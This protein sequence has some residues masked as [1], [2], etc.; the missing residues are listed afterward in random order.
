MRRVESGVMEGKKI[1]LMKSEDFEVRIIKFYKFLT[2]TKKEFVL[3]K[4]VLRSGTGIGA[5]LSE[6]EC[7]ISKSDWLAKVYIALKESNETLY[8]LRLLLKTDFINQA[9]FDSLYA[10]C[11]EIKRMLTASTKTAIARMQK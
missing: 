8:W 10:D 7:A 2:E 9:E 3:S 5:N 1:V 11:E 6:S 4:Q